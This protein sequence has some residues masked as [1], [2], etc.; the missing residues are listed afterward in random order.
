MEQ[1]ARRITENVT[2]LR[3]Q[4][5]AVDE[6]IAAAVAE[7]QKATAAISQALGETERLGRE[8]KGLAGEKTKQPQPASGA[9]CKEPF[10]AVRPSAREAGAPAAQHIKAASAAN[11]R[12]VAEFLL[13]AVNRLLDTHGGKK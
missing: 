5:T 12:G 13:D 4:L 6:K 10:E 11:K 7:M 1:S 8:V 3:S 9:P 2:L